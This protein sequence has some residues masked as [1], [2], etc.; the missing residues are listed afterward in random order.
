MDE[1]SAT[2]EAQRVLE[3]ERGRGLMERLRED[4]EADPISM[5]DSLTKH[6]GGRDPISHLARPAARSALP[7]RG[8]AEVCAEPWP[9]CGQD[10]RSLSLGA[11]LLAP[12]RL[13]RRH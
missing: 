11:L 8:T 12:P 5:M 1:F 7:A 4:V 3:A 9:V 2:L 6:E 13:E 10:P